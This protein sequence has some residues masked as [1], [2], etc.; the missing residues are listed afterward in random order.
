MFIFY[1]CIQKHTKCD[2]F[3]CGDTL[4]LMAC[5]YSLRRLFMNYNEPTNQEFLVS[6]S[7]FASSCL[8][9]SFLSPRISFG[10]LLWL[11]LF[12]VALRF[13]FSF[14]CSPPCLLL[15]QCSFFHF[16]FLRHSFHYLGG[17]GWSGQQRLFC[18]L[19]LLILL[20]PSSLPAL[21]QRQLLS[22]DQHLCNTFA[23]H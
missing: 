16:L 13:R 23:H 11:L 20:K 15:L 9:L 14:A 12:G 3:V 19:F 1:K 22:L 4:S 8:E 5:G 7:Y 2:L 6:T 10:N 17:G 21:F 18:L